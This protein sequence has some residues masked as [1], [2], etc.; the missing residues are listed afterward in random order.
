MGYAF[1]RFLWVGSLLACLF[2]NLSSIT[3]GA[4]PILPPEKSHLLGFR[5][6]R[7]DDQRVIDAIFV[8]RTGV[9]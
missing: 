8:L 1:G 2:V 5:C 7:V 6:Q 3:N 4:S 9:F